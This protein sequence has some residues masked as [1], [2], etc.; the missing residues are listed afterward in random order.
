MFQLV[1]KLPIFNAR[2]V[3]GCEPQVIWSQPIISSN[4]SCSSTVLSVSRQRLIMNTPFLY[5][6]HHF[7]QTWFAVYYTKCYC[8]KCHSLFSFEKVHAILRA[9]HIYKASRLPRAFLGLCIQRDSQV[10]TI[11]L[12]LSVKAWFQHSF[13]HQGE[14]FALWVL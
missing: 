5:S 3:W 2:T 10:F 1:K 12:S 6:R 9:G 11:S 8:Q 13:S 4:A 7:R 14:L